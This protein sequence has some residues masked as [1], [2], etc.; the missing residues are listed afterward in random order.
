MRAIGVLCGAL[1]LLS[2]SHLLA[3]EACDPGDWS[4]E[5]ADAA[6]PVEEGEA[7]PS[8]APAA[9]DAAA[10]TTTTTTT[11]TEGGSTV[12]V[13][14]TETGKSRVIVVDK[15]ANKPKAKKHRK[16]REWGINFRIEGVL[17]DDEDRD[18]D[19]GMGGLGFSFR[20]RPIPYFAVDAGFDFL[21]GIDWQ[22]NE[23]DETVFGVSGML[24]FNPRDKV[25]VYTLMGFD[26]SGAKVR[27]K[28]EDGEYREENERDY[29][30]F[31]AHLGGGLEWRVSR[32]VGLGV[33]VV[34]FIRGRTDDEARYE[35]EF[36][37][38]DTGRTTNTSGGGLFRGG[39]TFY[40]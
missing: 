21:G 38:E 32:K 8:E 31:G 29:R 40:W 19:A 25:Q 39:L 12:I 7:A 35:P 13:E 33:D 3:Q 37:D 4:C 9:T 14:Q 26:F 34:G 28:G 18:P 20:Y 17:M 16:K 36:V 30:Y 6:A 24:F 5:E 2:S 27:P 1:L 15:P 23:R 10:T 22:G 11:T